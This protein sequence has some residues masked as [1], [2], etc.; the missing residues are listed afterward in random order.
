MTLQVETKYVVCVN[1]DD[2]PASLE[3]RKIY[4]TLPDGVAAKHNLVRVID[5]SAED[6]LYPDS[7]FVP[8]EL[9]EEVENALP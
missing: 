5:E 4:R 7:C 2:Y 9:P 6:Y 8:I 1:N 3:V